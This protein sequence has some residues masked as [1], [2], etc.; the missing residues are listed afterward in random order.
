MGAAIAYA[1]NAG[2]VPI[3]K[4]GKLPYK[5]YEQPYQLEYGQEIMQVHQDAIKAGER[6]LVVDDLLATGGTVA[7]ALT[8]IQIFKADVVGIAFLIELKFLKGREKLGSL[9]IFS[10]LQY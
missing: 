4:K 9:P 1:L 2:I 3:R 8:L 6:V 5:V 10:I 7:A